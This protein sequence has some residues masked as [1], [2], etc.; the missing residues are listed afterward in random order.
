MLLQLSYFPTWNVS[1]K[2][3]ALFGKLNKMFFYTLLDIATAVNP[4]FLIAVFRSWGSLFG[5]TL[6]S[7]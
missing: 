2:I 5:R 6:L 4:D 3:P 7:A 1:V